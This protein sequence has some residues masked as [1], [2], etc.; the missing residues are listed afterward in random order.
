V[1][2]FNEKINY[3]LETPKTSET[4]E[5]TANDFVLI[6]FSTRTTKVLYTRQVEENEAFTC[7]VNVM[8]RHG[9]TLQFAFSDKDNKSEIEREDIMVNLHDHCLQVGLHALQH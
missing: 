3:L 9:E 7:K 2:N 1:K 8:G 6:R 5:I 4:Q